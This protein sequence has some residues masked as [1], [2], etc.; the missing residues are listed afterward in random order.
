MGAIGR[1]NDVAYD[2]RALKNGR[3]ATITVL[4]RCQLLTQST[5]GHPKY[6]IMNINNNL[7][8]NCRPNEAAR[9]KRRSLKVQQNIA[10]FPCLLIA[11]N[12]KQF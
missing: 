5:P 9:K 2:S 12:G 6:Q 3:L 11:F 8:Y 4:S 7:C 1:L 10:H